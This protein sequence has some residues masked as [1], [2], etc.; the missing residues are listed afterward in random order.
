MSWIR[1][2]TVMPDGKESDVYIWDDV[3]DRL[4]VALT[5]RPIQYFDY[6]ESFI[7]N[8]RVYL[9]LAAERGRNVPT[10]QWIEQ[11]CNEEMEQRK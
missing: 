6:N 11:A 4:A 10:R 7:D 5:D 8:V 3:S 9:Q 1:F 2:G